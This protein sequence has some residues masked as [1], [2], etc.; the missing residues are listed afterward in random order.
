MTMAS[1]GW[2]RWQAY[3]SWPY[4]IMLHLLCEASELATSPSQMPFP[5]QR[6]P[7]SFGSEHCGTA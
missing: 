7:P 4:S 3:I 2:R 6:G 1:V 5:S